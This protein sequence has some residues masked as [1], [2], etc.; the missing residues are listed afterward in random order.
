MLSVNI[1]WDK[2]ASARKFVEDY[3]LPFPVGRDSDAK[4]G[5]LYKT[6]ATPHSFFIDKAGILRRHVEGEM[7]EADF[8]REIEKLLTS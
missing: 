4:I 1:S 3:K 7:S 2:E 6:D 8:E 5:T